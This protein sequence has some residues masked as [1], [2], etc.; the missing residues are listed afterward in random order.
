MPRTIASALLRGGLAVFLAAC[1]DAAADGPL[2]YAG[3]GQGDSSTA[4]PGKEAGV[5]DGGIVGSSLP[6]ASA[7]ASSGDP[8]GWRLTWS[9]E[10]DAP[11]GSEVDSSKWN[12]DVGT[13]EEGWG[14]NELEY[15]TSG[16]A[17]AVIRGNALVITGATSG[18][19]HYTCAY[20]ACK[21]VSARLT[22]SNKFA[23]KYG[24]FEARIRLPRGRGVWPAFWMLGQNFPGVD[25]PDCGEIDVMENIGEPAI[26]YGTTHGPGPAK[27]VDVGLSGSTTLAGGA[28][29]D[30]FHLYATEWEA[31]AIRFYFDGQLYKTVTPADLPK[32]ATWVWDHP[33]FLIVNFAIGGDW[34]GSPDATTTWPQTMVVDYVRA[35]EATP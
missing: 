10:F 30:D 19:S 15:Y 27:Y 16:T 29:S 3:D 12:Y 11:D 23:Q 22:T 2:F 21:Y 13:G 26:V 14:N 5:A 35:Y 28:L 1:S 9:D 31:A 33:Y 17:N 34:P 20:G 24:R 32:G 4:V 8:P 7:D 25:W 18:A 6:E